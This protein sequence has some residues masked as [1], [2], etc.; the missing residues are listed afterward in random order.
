MKKCGYNDKL[1]FET[2]EQ[3]NKTNNKNKRKGNIIWYNP[4]FCSS[5]KT[6]IGRKF[7]NLVKKTFQQK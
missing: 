5:V 1:N 4:L 6:N 2:M 3:K 7:I